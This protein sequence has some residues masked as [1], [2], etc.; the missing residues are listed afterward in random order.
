MAAWTLRAWDE[1]GRL[2]VTRRFPTERACNLSADS[3]YEC[4]HVWRV[5]VALEVWGV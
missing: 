1:Q 4:G 3:L 5:A 2:I